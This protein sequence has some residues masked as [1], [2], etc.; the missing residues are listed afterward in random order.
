MPHK[1]LEVSPDPSVEK[2]TYDQPEMKEVPP[3]P[4]R[5]VILGPSG[6]GKTVLGTWLILNA[7]RYPAVQRV[8]V[9]SPSVDIDPLWKPVKKYS[10]EVLGVDPQ[11][12]QCFFPSFRH[13]DLDNVIKTQEAV[14]A[15]IK[16]QK[17]PPRK[18][19]N[20]II[21]I[22]DFADDPA[23]MRRETLL[24]KIYI[25]GRHIGISV[26]TLTQV[27]KALC[28]T[29]CKNALSV[30]IFKLR[31]QAELDSV[32][33]EVSAVAGGK[34]RALEL[35]RRAIAEPHGFLYCNLT[36]SDPDKVF[37]SKWEPMS[38]AD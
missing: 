3:L 7:Y 14:V 20:V 29:C 30:Y 4:T 26:L 25:R 31:N 28:P 9:W 33:E 18:I 11:E 22:D 12:E 23:F 19:P 21:C 36:S 38:V 37:H 32:L 5:A 16:K 2:A 6:T 34:K 13:E 10:E 17:G 24:R 35:Y 8:Y 15:C 1:S 27:W